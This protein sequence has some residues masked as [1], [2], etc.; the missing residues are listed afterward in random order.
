MTDY[1]KKGHYYIEEPRFELKRL[2]HLLPKNA[3]VLDMG[4][5]IG[6]NTK[7]FLENGYKVT[8]VEP[9]PTVIKTLQE[10]QKDYPKQLRVVE[11]SVDTYKPKEKFDVVI[12]CMVV[13]FMN[14]HELGV[15]AIHDIQSWTKPG[16]IN[17]LTGYMNN[18]PLS[19]D[20]SF[21]FKSNELSELYASWK[22]QWYQES[23]RI[24]WSRI[25]SPKD[26]PRLLLGKRGFKAARIIAQKV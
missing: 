7:F 1:S 2:S 26:I 12:C 22:S 19:K 3:H 13:H 14:N 11:D 17:L 18:Q 5:G 20:Y 4:A 15:K 25:Y 9:N 23:F 16:G 21:L 6:N 24:T 8:A 10:L